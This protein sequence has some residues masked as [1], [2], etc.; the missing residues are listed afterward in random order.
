MEI[1]ESKFKEYLE[2]LKIINEKIPEV[3]ARKNEARAEGDLK[4][5]TEFDVAS[6]ELEQLREQKSDLEEIIAKATVIDSSHNSGRI[7]IGSFVDITCISHPDVGR[8]IL[9]LDANGTTIDKDPMKRILSIHSKLG[10]A[11][12]NS[13]SGTYKIQTERGEMT[14]TVKQI[15]YDEAKRLA[16]TE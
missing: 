2:E 14:Y 8:R 7:G 4:E 6:Y 1:S 11:I 3:I 16:G 10:S 5:N 12:A 15:T 13:V 9:R